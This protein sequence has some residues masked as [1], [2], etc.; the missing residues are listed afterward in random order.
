MTEDRHLAAILAPRTK[1]QVQAALDYS[2]VGSSSVQH[3]YE[4]LGH[5]QL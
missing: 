3:D 2:W 4:R 1:I 5:A